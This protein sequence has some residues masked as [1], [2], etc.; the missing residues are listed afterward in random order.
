MSCFDKFCQPPVIVHFVSRRIFYS[1]VSSVLT[2]ASWKWNDVMLN[3]EAVC[4]AF[5]LYLWG[6]YTHCRQEVIHLSV[7]HKHPLVNAL[8]GFRTETR[9][10]AH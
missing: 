8:L 5:V 3:T 1:S 6:K 7:L 4:G 9:T 10:L 2:P